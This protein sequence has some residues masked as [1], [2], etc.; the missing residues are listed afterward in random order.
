[1]MFFS[2]IHPAEN[3]SIIV[4]PINLPFF[5]DVT[6]KLFQHISGL[7]DTKYQMTWCVEHEKYP[8]CVR[9][10]TVVSVIDDLFVTVYRNTLYN[11]FF[12]R[13]DNFLQSSVPVCY[14]LNRFC[15]E[16][17]DNLA[18]CICQISWLT[19]IYCKILIFINLCIVQCNLLAVSLGIS[20]C[21]FNKWDFIICRVGNNKPR[22]GKTNSQR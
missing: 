8:N 6:S 15:S 16:Y 20:W 4:I 10:C 11:L 12:A 7:F 18:E 21:I 22:Q 14:L 3:W 1:M 13:V 5:P 19:I 9:L 17:C 2:K